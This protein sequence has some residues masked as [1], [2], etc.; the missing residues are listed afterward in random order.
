MTILYEPSPKQQ[1]F[2]ACTVDELLF[3]GAAG[4]GK[5]VALV[6]DILPRVQIEHDRCLNRKKWG[7]NGLHWGASHGWSLHL[8]RSA[9]D[10]QQ[11][12]RYATD[13]YRAVDPGCEYVPKQEYFLF[14]SGYRAQFGHCFELN[15]WNKY[16]GNAYDYIAFDELVQ[17][18]EEQYDKITFRL[19]SSDPILGQRKMLKVRAASNPMTARK[20]DDNW[21]IHDPHWV[22]KRFVEPAPQGNVVLKQ[23]VVKSDRSIA[24]VTRMYMPARLRDN[25]NKQFVEE[26][27]LQLSK[28]PPAMRAA[29]RD[30]D[31]FKTAGSFFA[32]A[33]DPDIHVCRPFN[34]PSYWPQW[35]SGD[36]GHKKPGCI[37]W[38]AMDEDGN[39]FCTRELTFQGRD[40]AWVAER[41][42][43]IEM[44]NGQW[45]RRSGRSKLT[46]P[47]DPQLWERRGDVGKSK[48]QTFS[49]HGISW[50]PADKTNHTRARHAERITERLNDHGGGSKTPGLVFFNTCTKIIQTLPAIQTDP[51]DPESPAD[52][53]DDH[54]LDST[55]YSVT[56]ASHGRSGLGKPMDEEDDGWPEG[57]EK[58]RDRGQ[59]GYGGF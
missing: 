13:F 24:Y 12:L 3:A 25:P 22:R 54:W 37:H 5:T 42:K 26:Y 41:V 19:R 59:W 35:R 52:G 36:W 17:F 50:V 8:R 57:E 51:N 39:I 1:E 9:K 11:T 6:A 14:S 34:I 47:M 49:D 29:Y 20:V 58:E 33:W 7:A 31:W 40:A 56:Y 32:E 43:M 46:G 53:G 28:L 44:D 30:G 38:W 18:T 45:D 21:S 2:H 10:L 23:K 27:D 48:A 16:I 4:P 55:G 15:D